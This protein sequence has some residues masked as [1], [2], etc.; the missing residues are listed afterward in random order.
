MNHEF[1]Y[2]SSF[3]EK[4]FPRPVWTDSEISA[5]KLKVSQRLEARWVQ[6]KYVKK[7][8][9]ASWLDRQFDTKTRLAC[10]SKRVNEIQIESIASDAPRV[11]RKVKNHWCE[12]LSKSWKTGKEQLVEKIVEISSKGC[13]DLYIWLV[14]DQIQKTWENK[15]V[16]MASANSTEWN[17]LGPD[18]KML[19][20]HKD[21]EETFRQ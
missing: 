15:R 14:T 8:N 9:E 21:F 16:G 18:M 2:C 7:C 17:K 19:W 11:L 1:G 4:E 13:V 20:D 12:Y 3:P 5:A 10:N 6:S